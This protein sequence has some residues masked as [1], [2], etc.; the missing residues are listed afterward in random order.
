MKK[1]EDAA[2]RFAEGVHEFVTVEIGGRMFGVAVRD[3]HDVFAPQAVTPVPLSAPEIAG[4]L[5]LRGRIVTA[6]DARARLGLPPPARREEDAPERP[7][8]AIGIE[9]GG[10]SY[11]LIIDRV[12][13]VLRL[14]GDDFEPNAASLDPRWRRMTAGVFRLP[15]RLLIVLDI[16][17]M[18][19]VSCEQAA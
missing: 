11:G 16:D 3:I 17:A 15:E 9:T 19:D 2:S 18:L 8:M 13:E 4:V 12:G 7:R 14:D 1:G 5:N 6:I 10:E